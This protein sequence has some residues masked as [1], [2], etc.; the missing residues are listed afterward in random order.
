MYEFEKKV[1]KMKEKM[2][3]DP[4]TGIGEYLPERNCVFCKHCKG[5]CVDEFDRFTGGILCS[6]SYEGFVNETTGYTCTNFTEEE[7][8]D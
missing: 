1:L 2:W 6:I 7:L 3:R 8:E 4:E 5:R